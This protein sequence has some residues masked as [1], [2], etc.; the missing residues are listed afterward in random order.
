[1]SSLRP[2][3]E[4]CNYSEDA[5]KILN[6]EN[7]SS[8][9]LL[10]AIIF[11]SCFSHLVFPVSFHPLCQYSVWASFYWLAAQSGSW[12]PTPACWSQ[13][14][15]RPVIGRRCLHQPLVSRSILSDSI[16]LYFTL[17]SSNL[18]LILT[19]SDS[20]AV[21]RWEPC[22]PWQWRDERK[23]EIEKKKK[24]KKRKKTKKIY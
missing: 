5:E 24:K 19:A 7:C 17:W 14:A 1:M 6:T 16:L 3:G 20:A 22:C 15:L 11:V 21:I 2:Q 8:H 23:A 9:Y 4:L 18:G 13:R 10:L 12:G